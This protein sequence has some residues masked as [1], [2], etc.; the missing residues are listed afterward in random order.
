MHRPGDMIRA[1]RNTA[2]IVLYAAAA[3]AQ[4]PA[5]KVEDVLARLDDL[6][7]S[8]ASVAQVELTISS[9]RVNRTLRL[10]A[11]TKGTD[12]ALIRIESPP[13]EA[14]IV[15]LRVGQNLW[16]YLPKLARTMRVP[17]SMML[18]SWMGTDFTNDDLVHESSMRDDYTS[19]LDRWD[20][21]ANGW[22]ITSEARPGIAARWAKIQTLVTPELLPVE[23]R[24]FDRQGALARTL[25]YDEVR[26][27]GKRRVPARMTLVPATE[28]ASRTV[29]RYLQLELDVD[30]PDDTFSLARLEQLR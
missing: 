6:Y 22:W 28:D 13:R 11:W 30:V 4:P 5:P 1:R 21:E 10:R 27:F 18:A 29:L 12:R 23:M 14:G 8:G 2:L 25:Q 17:P 16:N 19:R 26:T 9:P 20:A 3:A 15:T 24:F 7:R